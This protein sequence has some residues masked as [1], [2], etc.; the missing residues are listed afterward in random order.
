MKELLLASD[1]YDKATTG[2]KNIT[3]RTG[4]RDFTPGDPIK[5]VDAEDDNQ[6]IVRTVLDVLQT[7]AARLPEEYQR[8]DGF[9]SKVE[10]V[11]LM[12]NYYPDFDLGSLITVIGWSV[13]PPL[14]F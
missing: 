3:I 12:R 10:M 14:E 7:T 8:A 11:Q 5:L 4:L 9:T 13:L 2:E 1:L 6:F